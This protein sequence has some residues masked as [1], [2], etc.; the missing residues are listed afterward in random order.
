MSGSAGKKADDACI[1]HPGTEGRFWC[2]KYT[3][4][5]CEECA[6]CADPA[7]HCTFRIE[8][9]VW[10]LERHGD[11]NGRSRSGKEKGRSH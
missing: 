4:R 6:R 3:R 10:E 2:M 5:L 7:Q 8:C 9:V 1:N 11:K